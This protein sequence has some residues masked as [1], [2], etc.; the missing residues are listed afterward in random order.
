MS[1]YC[2][3]THHVPYNVFLN[4]VS[5]VGQTWITLKVGL[6]WTKC[7]LIDSTQFQR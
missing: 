6:T 2:R 4:F 1:A 3:G 7:D 5:L